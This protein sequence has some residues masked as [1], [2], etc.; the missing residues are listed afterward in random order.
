M[1]QRTTERPECSD[2]EQK[3][4]GA[5]LGR[6]AK[7]VMVQGVKFVLR[8]VLLRPATWHWLMVKFPDY[9]D[10]AVQMAKAVSAWFSDSF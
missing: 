1:K 4:V 5:P 7:K 9:W 3:H 2:L 6:Q 10:E 8:A